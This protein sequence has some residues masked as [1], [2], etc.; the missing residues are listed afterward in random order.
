MG[1]SD[2]VVCDARRGGA[3][4]NNRFVAISGG[5][6]GSSLSLLVRDTDS[7][8]KD[9][10]S[11][12]RISSLV[13]ELFNGLAVAACLTIFLAEGSFGVKVTAPTLIAFATLAGYFARNLIP[14]ILQNLTVNVE[15]VRESP[16]KH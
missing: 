5:L 2:T 8:L 1:R 16:P 7:F 15:T 3:R 10:F 14:E 9:R 12:R 11:A 6:L 13:A 4:P